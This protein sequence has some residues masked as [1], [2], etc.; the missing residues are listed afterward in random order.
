MATSLQTTERGPDFLLGVMFYGR[1]Q[2]Q[3]CVPVADGMVLKAQGLPVDSSPNLPQP[4]L[5]PEMRPDLCCTL[6]LP[7]VQPLGPRAHVLCLTATTSRPL[8][9]LPEGLAPEDLALPWAP[10]YSL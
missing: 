5:S 7:R 3:L 2:G 10:S 9:F 4:H 1:P 8:R 6:G